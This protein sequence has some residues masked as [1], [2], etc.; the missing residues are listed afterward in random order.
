[1]RNF[2]LLTVTF[3]L[4]AAL[5]S[6]CAPVHADAFGSDED[7]LRCYTGGLL[8][9]LRT[10]TDSGALKDLPNDL[11]TFIGNTDNLSILIDYR[12]KENKMVVGAVRKKSSKVEEYRTYQA[13]DAE[14]KLLKAEFKKLKA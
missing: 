11:K 2:W 1:M 13:D 7:G 3:A 12:K 5:L 4:L 14:F 8:A 9:E 10:R 6:H